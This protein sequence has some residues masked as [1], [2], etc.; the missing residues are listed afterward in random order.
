M[1]A[2]LPQGVDNCLFVEVEVPEVVSDQFPLKLCKGEVDVIKTAAVD[3][4]PVD[5]LLA[6]RAACPPRGLVCVVAEW[7]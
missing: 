1:H 4:I 3:A 2:A 6:A 5:E 7:P